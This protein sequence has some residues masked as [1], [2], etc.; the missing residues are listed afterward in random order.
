VKYLFLLFIA[1]LLSFKAYGRGSEADP[2]SEDEDDIMHTLAREGR[3]DLENERWN[4]YGQ[5][6]FISQWMN[7]FPAAYTNLN[8]STN[9][10]LPN[11]Q[12]SFSWTATLFFG[13]KLWD[14]GEIYAVPEVISEMPFSGLKGLGGDIQNFEMQ[15]NGGQEP[16]IYTARAYYKQTVN[17]GG[18]AV[19][20]DSDP[21]QLG[22]KVESRRFTFAFGKFSLL[23]FF[24][25]NTYA[26]D[27]RRQF[28]NMSFMA[29]AAYDFAADSKGYTFGFVGEQTWDN[30]A[31]RYGRAAATYQPNQLDLNYDLF[32][33]YGEQL[34]I[35][36][37]NELWGHPGSIRILGMHNHENMGNF[38]DAMNVYK[39]NP[40]QY[41]STTCNSFNY[42][43]QNPTAPDLCW[44]RK[45]QD[46]YG[47]G[48]NIEQ[49]LRSDLGVFF[50]GF[51]NDGN[52]E[53]YS[54]T[55]TDRSLSLGGL[56]TGQEWDR[57][58]DTLGLGF[59]ANWISKSHA[60]YL[61]MGGI[62]G[63]IGDGAISQASEHVVDVFYSLNLANPFWVTADYQHISNPGYNSVRGPVNV[64]GVRAHLEF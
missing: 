7:A 21:L 52:T 31:I 20:L 28:F 61:G 23:D 2:R 4:F 51:W 27:L 9:S 15:K 26:G 5:T 43:N 60:Q 45:P 33:Y 42:G 3:H 50:R 1:L 12:N 36:Y 64:F 10:L 22:S 57:P 11:A 38:N 44:V 32:T 40:S 17:M 24:D 63:F 56:L 39:S 6:T 49:E 35:Q 47:I 41:N 53:V 59:S 58:K 29:S 46:K 34:E 54:Y 30:W 16:V 25:R 48:I 14:G 18:E 62:D 13:L 55:S 19:Q 8:G 37:S